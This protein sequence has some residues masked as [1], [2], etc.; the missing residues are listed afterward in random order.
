MDAKGA[1]TKSF[2]STGPPAMSS[3]RQRPIPSNVVATKNNVPLL[4]VT[5]FEGAELSLAGLRSPSSTVPAAVPSLENGSTPAG[6]L[7]AVKKNLLVAAT[8]DTGEELP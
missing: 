5:K 3:V 1:S 6:P 2:T 4:V 8:N 7:S